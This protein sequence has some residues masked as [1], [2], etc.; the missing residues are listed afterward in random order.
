MVGKIAGVTPPF[1]SHCFA[2][3][4][5]HS[6]RMAV[7][8]IGG[9]DRGRIGCLGVLSRLRSSPSDSEAADTAQTHACTFL[10]I[11]SSKQYPIIHEYYNSLC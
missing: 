1:S 3:F 2:L 4:P 10:I 7:A 9:V 11:A 6:R 5:A 8:L